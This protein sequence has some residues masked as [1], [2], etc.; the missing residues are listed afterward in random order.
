M[1]LGYWH[2]H[3]DHRRPVRN[4]LMNSTAEHRPHRKSPFGLG[5]HDDLQE[6]DLPIEKKN[7]ISM[8]VLLLINHPIQS[9]EST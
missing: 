4:Y 3:V 9:D 5:H 8:Y 2:V 7:K 1:L 6:G